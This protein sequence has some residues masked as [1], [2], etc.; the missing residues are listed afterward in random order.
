MFKRDIRVNYG[1]LDNLIGELKQYSKALEDI[2]K[3]L[4]SIH[5]LLANGRGKT[6]TVFQKKI[7]GYLKRIDVVQGELTDLSNI[8]QDYIADMTNIIKPIRRGSL[9]QVDRNDIYWNKR[10]ILEACSQVPLMPMNV[11][12]WGYSDGF[13]LDDSKEEKA[14][15]RRNDEKLAEIKNLLSHSDKQ[16]SELVKQL[17]EQ[18]KK[19][20]K[21]E[22]MDD[23]YVKRANKLKQKYTSFWEGAGDVFYAIKNF[24]TKLYDGM[25]DSIID[26]FKGLGCL[27]GGVVKYGAS[28]V[29]YGFGKLSGAD[30]PDWAETCYNDTNETVSAVLKD[31]FL[32]VEGL[33]QGVSDSFE[34][35][36]GAYCGGYAVGTVAVGIAGNKGIKKVKSL[37]KGTKEVGAADDVVRGTEGTAVTGKGTKVVRR[38]TKA[39]QGSD[40]LGREIEKG[41]KGG[42]G[43]W[44]M[45][46]EGGLINGREYSQHVM[47]R[48]APD[49]PSVRAELSRRAERA[50]EQYGYKVGTKEYSDFCTK[51][52]DPRN[53]PPSVIEDAISSTKAVPGNR[54]NTFIHET[55]DV[56]IVV[57]SSGK[58]VTVI[59]K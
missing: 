19:V 41:I 32:I 4:N 54:P 59:P 57:N 10:A 44:D 36:G 24:K 52:V 1:S 35:K 9:M 11:K 43:S 47:E 45:T 53:I 40:D 50:A 27:E 51:Y 23:I 16:F 5:S 28:A 20:M 38:V 15:K 56:K 7:K 29:V 30:V 21:Y 17:D 22:N 8:V 3:A 48:M 49:T 13:T 39:G 25:E 34:E 55:A 2:E 33:S 58:V 6:T 12:V 46:E 31:P 18:Y 37:R 14:R 42:S 26:F